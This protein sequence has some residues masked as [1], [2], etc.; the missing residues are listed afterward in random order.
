M[1]FDSHVVFVIKYSVEV[2][3]VQLV[4]N[5]ILEENLYRSVDI[6]VSRPT[7]TG[8]WIKLWILLNCIGII[9]KSSRMKSGGY[10]QVGRTVMRLKLSNLIPYVHDISKLYRSEVSPESSF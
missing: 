7:L 2:R 8:R 9:L 3:P 1:L 10:F 4:S 6:M 5:L